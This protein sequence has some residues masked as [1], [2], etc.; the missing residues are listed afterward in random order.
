MN[1]STNGCMLINV[2]QESKGPILNIFGRFNS[3]KPK[4][5]TEFCKCQLTSFHVIVLNIKT[6]PEDSVSYY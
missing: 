1:E 2:F 3:I 6:N 5:T 4:V